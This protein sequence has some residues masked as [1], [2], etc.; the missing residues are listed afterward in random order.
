MHRHYNYAKSR[1]KTRDFQR[2]HGFVVGSRPQRNAD[3]RSPSSAAKQQSPVDVI[4][5]RI[6]DESNAFRHEQRKSAAGALGVYKESFDDGGQNQKLRPNIKTINLMLNALHNSADIRDS[7]RAMYFWGEMQ[8]FDLA[9]NSGTYSDMIKN[10]T[11]LGMV[12]SAFDFFKERQRKGLPVAPN[13]PH[14]LLR[15]CAKVGDFDRADKFIKAQ[16]DSWNRGSNFAVSNMVNSLLELS[17]G[18][19]VHRDLARLTAYNGQLVDI[20]LQCPE[21]NIV[22]WRPILNAITNGM[23]MSI[24]YNNAGSAK[25]MLSMLNRIPPEGLQYNGLFSV[26]FRQQSAVS[27]DESCP[28]SEP[29]PLLQLERGMVR[30]LLFLAARNGCASLAQN[31][32]DLASEYGYVLSQTETRAYLCAT[33]ESYRRDVDSDESGNDDDGATDSFAMENLVRVVSRMREIGGV[34][35]FDKSAIDDLAECFSKSIYTID[36]A[37]Y[38]L[39]EMRQAGRAATETERDAAGPA[40]ELA[41]AVMRASLTLNDSDRVL[42][43]LREWDSICSEAVSPLAISCALESTRIV[44]KNISE[45]AMAEGGTVSYETF[46]QARAQM[47]ECVNDAVKV[48]SDL[49][50]SNSPL[51]FSELIQARARIATLETAQEVDNG[52]SV[53]SIVDMLSDVPGCDEVSSST[54]YLT[55]A[56]RKMLRARAKLYDW[57]EVAESLAMRSS[58]LAVGASPSSSIDPARGGDSPPTAEIGAI[59]RSDEDEDG[60]ISPRTNGRAGG[61]ASRM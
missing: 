61:G 6:Q 41:C 13:D 49:G 43:T 22:K 12:A 18:A 32:H 30:A 39:Q 57:N 34:N 25:A 4:N 59:F 31:V 35:A 42:E 17:E 8:K 21:E 29:P 60:P 48:A 19:A 9:P 37:F 46:E 40:A 56:A 55:N 53:A 50:M 15:A 38:E 54:L 33:L 11:K 28:V 1:K 16:F 3:A 27:D 51:I 47:M 10:L 5:R 26:I 44:E 58:R 24:N 7:S 23:I 45:H 52:E 2:E 14:V 20:S 36:S